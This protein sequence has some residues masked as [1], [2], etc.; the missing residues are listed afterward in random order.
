MG[1]MFSI[2]RKGVKEA[3]ENFGEVSITSVS[4]KILEEI[5]T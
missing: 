5:I 4:E 1:D 3:L 2:F